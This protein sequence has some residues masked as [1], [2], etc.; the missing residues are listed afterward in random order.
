MKNVKSI[1]IEFDFISEFFIEEKL[2]NVSEKGYPGVKS[3]VGQALE[4]GLVKLD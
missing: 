2:S 4:L 3:S 1:E